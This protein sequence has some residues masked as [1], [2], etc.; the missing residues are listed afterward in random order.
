MKVLRVLGCMILGGPFLSCALYSPSSSQPVSKNCEVPA[1][2]SGTISGKWA[3]GPIPVAFQQGAFSAD[4]IRAI[5]AAMDTWNQFSMKAQGVTMFDYGG[6]ATEPRLSASLNPKASNSLCSSGL[7]QST[8]FKG[9]VVIY[10]LGTWPSN[11]A[12]SAMALTTYCTIPGTPYNSFFSAVMELNY[13]SFFAA[14]TGRYPDLQT[15]TLH[16]FGHLV[17]LNHSCEF[18]NKSGTP[19]CSSPSLNPEYFIASMYPRFG[20]DGS[21]AGEVKQILR[22]NDQ[23]RTNCIY[24]PTNTKIA[25]APTP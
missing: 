19:N 9:A 10:K 16:E 5:T 17:G 18:D 3:I 21:G 8:S 22:T 15:I 25:G 23:T 11:Y 2:Q 14:G 1:D 20:F 13:Q 7:I 6:S 24:S 12:S 4:E